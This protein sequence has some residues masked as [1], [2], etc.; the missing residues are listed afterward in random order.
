LLDPAGIRALLLCHADATQVDC[1]I[2]F[3]HLPA[4]AHQALRSAGLLE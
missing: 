1:R 4:A 3:V 2:V